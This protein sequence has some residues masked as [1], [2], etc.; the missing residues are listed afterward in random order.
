MIK[1]LG[2]IPNSISVAVSGGVDSMVA[3][4]FLNNGKR[5]IR[6]L[7]FNHGTSHSKEAEAFVRDYCSSFSIPCVV[8]TVDKQKTDGVSWEEYWRNQ[9]YS[10]FSERADRPIVTAHHLNDAIEWWIFSSLHGQSKLI[11][12]DN[13]KYNIIRPF[14][15]ATKES[16]VSW[17]ERKSVPFLQ[18]PSNFS[19]EHMRNVIRH[20]IVPTATLVNPGLEK[21]ISKRL[22]RANALQAA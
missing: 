3:L 12:R 11:P 14:L 21:T 20:D 6:V 5:N 4:D 22:I 7:H 8:G 16:M 19:R 2:K 9:R 15:L 18:D 10:F 13:D 17:A 1:L